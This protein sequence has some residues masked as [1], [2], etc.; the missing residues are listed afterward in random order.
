MNIPPQHK[1]PA[2]LELLTITISTLPEQSL[3]PVPDPDITLTSE[4]EEETYE[5]AE[6]NCM[7]VALMFRPT[8]FKAGP[9]EDF[10][11]KNDDTM[12]WLLAMKAYF[13][14]NEKSILKMQPPS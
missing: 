4:G 1:L 8:K 10:S 14:I 5:P 6:D 9:P 11:G 12:H 3:E 2:A 7:E 13:I